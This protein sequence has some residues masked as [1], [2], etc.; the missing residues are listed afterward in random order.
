VQK[1]RH[2]AGVTG[3]GEGD[4]AVDGAAAAEVA[5]GAAGGGGFGASC[6]TAP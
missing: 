2:F 1:P 6:F 3:A 4:A 5:A